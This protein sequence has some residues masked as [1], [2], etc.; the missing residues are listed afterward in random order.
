MVLLSRGSKACWNQAEITLRNTTVTP[1]ANMLIC[2]NEDIKSLKVEGKNKD[3]IYRK[4]SVI[5]LGEE[6]MNSDTENRVENF[7]I[8]TEQA[9]VVRKCLPSH[10]VDLTLPIFLSMLR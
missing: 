3:E 4:L 8:V 9:K 6:P 7:K 10:A 1:K 2:T 5:D